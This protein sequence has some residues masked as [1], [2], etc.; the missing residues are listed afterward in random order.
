MRERGGASMK[1]M[2]K[3]V[4]VVGCGSV[5]SEVADTLATSGVGHLTL[6]DSDVLSA[7]NVFRHVLGPDAIGAY[8]VHALKAQLMT[9]YPELRVTAEPEDIEKWLRKSDCAGIDGVVVAVG[10][11]T[12]ERRLARELRAA[13][14]SA[15]VVFTWLEALD[16]GGHAVL[17]SMTSEGCVDCLYRNEDG[18]AGLSSRTAFLQAGQ[19]VTRNLTGCASVFVPYGALQSRQTALQ[20][21]GLMLDALGSRTTAPTYRYWVGPGVE[22]DA[23]GL[24]MTGWWQRAATTTSQAATV[25]AF[26]PYCRNCRQTL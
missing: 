6:V 23:H 8:K 12:L 25:S 15:P 2:T 21:S 22:A 5:G 11:P 19:R 4:V 26:R 10:A 18:E 9:R 24:R 20:A 17:L 16:L 14:L 7:A 13:K 3:H 1:L